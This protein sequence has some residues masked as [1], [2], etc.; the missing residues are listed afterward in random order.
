[1]SPERKPGM[2]R[3][4]LPKGR[5]FDQI[6]DLLKGAGISIQNSAR[7]YRPNISLPNYSTKILKP[8]NVIGML[9]VCARDLGFAGADWVVET[10]AEVQEILD[11]KLNPVRVVVAA[12]TQVLENGK[13]PNRR[14][15]VATEYPELAKKWIADNQL[16]ATVLQAFGATEVFPPED[17]DC[18]LDNTATGSTLRANGLEIIDEVMR[19]TTRL[20]ASSEAM[21]DP[22]RKKMIDDFVMLIQSVLLARTRV[23][24]DLN[25]EQANLQAVLDTLPSMRSPTVSSLR[26][27]DWVAI[28]SAVPR[29]ELAL[30]LP[31][32][33]AVGARDIVITAAEQLVP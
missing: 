23:M 10:G 32:L 8:R 29:K 20:Y 9:D 18:I 33:E 2:I 26:D 22:A 15:V 27:S 25:V 28:R 13:L 12:P 24:M 14:I 4:A 17:A 21:A 6:V 1:M 3:L 11:T 30:I 7:G 31:K 19:S 16:D 5:M